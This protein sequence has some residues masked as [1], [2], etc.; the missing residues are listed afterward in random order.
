MKIR[1]LKLI[2]Y[3]S[4]DQGLVLH[5]Y[6]ASA[7]RLDERNS[8]SNTGGRGKP[9]RGGSQPSTGTAARGDQGSST[10][11]GRALGPAGVDGAWPG[12]RPQELEGK[13]SAPV[14]TAGSSP[15]L[16]PCR[17]CSSLKYLK[18]LPSFAALGL[19]WKQLKGKDKCLVC[20][21]G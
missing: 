15:S 1:G 10:E 12:K 6:C 4:N 2:L 7:S 21:K 13:P 8:Q 11:R 20:P 18:T 16:P 3:Y 19:G 14:P 17:Q 5:L 9:G